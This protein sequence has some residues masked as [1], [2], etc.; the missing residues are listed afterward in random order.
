M[1]WTQEEIEYLDDNLGIK[2]IATIAMN[3]RKNPK[4]VDV[5]RL[6][7]GKPSCRDA[8]DGIPVTEFAAAIGRC[9]ETIYDYVS[10]KGLPITCCYRS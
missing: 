9:T 3:I 2:S 7:N 10:Q 6:R 8:V 5:Y 4:S 1:A